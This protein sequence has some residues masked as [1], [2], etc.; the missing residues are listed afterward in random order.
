MR[1][2]K[3]LLRVRGLIKLFL[4]VPCPLSFSSTK[5]GRISIFPQGHL[6]AFRTFDKG[7]RGRYARDA[8]LWTE[9]GEHGAVGV[10]SDTVDLALPVDPPPSI[11]FGSN[12]RRVPLGSLYCSVR[13]PP[14]SLSRL[15]RL[16]VLHPEI[17]SRYQLCFDAVKALPL[18]EGRSFVDLDLALLLSR[19]PGRLRSPVLYLP[20]PSVGHNLFISVTSFSRLPQMLEAMHSG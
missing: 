1:E 16:N 5:A 7:R 11:V 4:G 8:K 13:S 10:H 6:R 19:L 2:R 18:S 9:S 20:F 15:E 14:S 3:G 12:A 17:P